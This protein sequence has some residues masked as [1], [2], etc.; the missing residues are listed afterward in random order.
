MSVAHNE[1]EPDEVTRQMAKNIIKHDL[2]G[3]VELEDCGL[4]EEIKI[5]KNTVENAEVALGRAQEFYDSSLDYYRATIEEI[6][7]GSLVTIVANAD[8]KIG[9]YQAQ[10][11]RQKDFVAK[12]ANF[13]GKRLAMEAPGDILTLINDESYVKVK[14]DSLVTDWD[15]VSFA[16]PEATE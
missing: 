10:T 2:F 6:P 8:K 3:V 14:T 11:G 9:T 15:L 1:Q 7:S 4:A 16:E 5:I 13:T 12:G